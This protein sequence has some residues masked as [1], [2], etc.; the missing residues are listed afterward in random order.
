MESLLNDTEE[1]YQSNFQSIIFWETP[2]NNYSLIKIIDD[3]LGNIGLKLILVGDNKQ[4]E[5]NVYN[6]CLFMNKKMRK[7]RKCYLSVEFEIE[8][9]KD[10]KDVKQKFIG[11][12]V[13]Y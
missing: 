3:I 1:F 12:F 4:F 9:A 11:L 6:T 8:K 7:L 2:V 5:K 10:L 13:F